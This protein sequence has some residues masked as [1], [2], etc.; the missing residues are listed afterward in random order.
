VASELGTA[1]VCTASAHSKAT[2]AVYTVSLP[3]RQCVHEHTLSNSD[4]NI[5][6][7]RQASIDFR[8]TS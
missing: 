2:A 5:E 8:L 4:L 7:H 6:F 1:S 3:V